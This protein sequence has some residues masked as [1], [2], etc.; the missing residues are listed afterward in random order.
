ME[1][2][3]RKEE[4]VVEDVGELRG[5]GGKIVTEVDRRS[6]AKLFSAR[7]SRAK[8]N[9]DTSLLLTGDYARIN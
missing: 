7:T 4:A 1:E 8:F 9:N 6:L 3:K 2:R 5:S